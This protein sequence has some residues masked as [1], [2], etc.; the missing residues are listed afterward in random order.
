MENHIKSNDLCKRC[1]YAFDRH[2]IEKMKGSCVGCVMD[3]TRDPLGCK[4]LNIK[5]NT[6]CQYFVE[7]K[8]DDS[9]TEQKI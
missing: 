6:P 9:I 2:C 4:C 5:V 1:I 8:D 3:V 7:E